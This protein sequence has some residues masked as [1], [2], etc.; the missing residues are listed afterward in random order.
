[1]MKL[2]QTALLSVLPLMMLFSVSYAQENAQPDPK[3]AET[4]QTVH[5]QQPPQPVVKQFDDWF[6]RCVFLASDEQDKTTKQCEVAQI[7][8]VQQ[9]DQM[10]TVLSVAIAMSE[11]EKKGGKHG[12][13]MTSVAPLNVFLPVGLRYTVGGKDVIKTA[14]SNCNQAG[15]WARQ[16]LDK[17]MLDNLRNGNEGE[18]HF[19]LADGRNVNIKFSLKGLSSALEALEKDEDI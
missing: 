6:Y 3:D 10:I 7:Q 13:V 16:A 18:S 17:R 15:C 5:E 1:M 4:Q 19:R 14:Y 9:G 8:R 2:I 12:L 11:P